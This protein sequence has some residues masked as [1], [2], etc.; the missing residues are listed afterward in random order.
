MTT[1]KVHRNALK[2]T[3]Y[4]LKLLQVSCASCINGIENALKTVRDIGNFQVNFATRTVTITGNA[5]P[6]IAIK[7][8]QSAG[9]NASLIEPEQ[10]ASGSGQSEMLHMRQQ[11][12]KALLAGAIGIALFILSMLPWKPTLDAL[13]GQLTWGVLGLITLITIGYSGGHLYRAAW[14]AFWHHLATMDTLITIGTG[15]AW[16]YSMVIVVWPMLVPE[17]ARHVY[18]EAALII[19]ALVDLGAALE[20]RARGK[21]SEAIKRLIGLQ[22][23]TARRIDTTGNE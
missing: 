17:S 21:T 6:Q 11:I 9:Y 8:I 15:A 23:K 20:I 16:I 3:Q 13:I 7:A 1:S 14:S 5:A 10:E 2:S 22:A 12:R 4:Q 18:F 19:I